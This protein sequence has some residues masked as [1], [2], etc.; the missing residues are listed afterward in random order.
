M[1]VPRRCA[2]RDHT[3]ERT[4]CC[5][6]C[7]GVL[8]HC[9]HLVNALVHYA[10]PDQ[11]SDQ[12]TC[13]TVC[14]VSSEHVL[15]LLVYAALNCAHSGMYCLWCSLADDVDLLYIPY[16]YEHQRKIQNIWHHCTARD[17]SETNMHIEWLPIFISRIIKEVCQ[18]AT[19]SVWYCFTVWSSSEKICVH[20]SEYFTWKQPHR[21]WYFADCVSS[22]ITII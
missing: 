3:I 9:H 16:C 21:I 12:M 10:S 2:S 5:M 4:T 11:G 8:L 22:C 19:A 1:D 15:L 14:I 20:K 7:N 17:Q 18:T 6:L 13:C